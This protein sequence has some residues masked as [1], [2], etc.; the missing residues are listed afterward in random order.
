MRVDYRELIIPNAVN[1]DP[2][3]ANLITRVLTAVALSVVALNGTAPMAP[4]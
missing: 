4:S 1:A 3:T 2:N